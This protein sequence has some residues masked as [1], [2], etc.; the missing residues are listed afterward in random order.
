MREKQKGKLVRPGTIHIRAMQDVDGQEACV[1]YWRFESADVQGLAES[2]ARLHI[3][4]K[5]D[6]DALLPL[7]SSLS[8]GMEELA[9]D[10]AE[11]EPLPDAAAVLDL[12]AEGVEDALDEAAQE[13]ALYK[14][15]RVF[16]ISELQEE[17]GPPADAS[18][19]E[20]ES[21][22]A[23]APLPV[24]ELKPARAPKPVTDLKPT[25]APRAA[26][27]QAPTPVATQHDEEIDDRTVVDPEDMV[28]STDRERVETLQSRV[29][30]PIE[31]SVLI[32][33]LRTVTV[34]P[35]DKRHLAV[36]IIRCAGPKIIDVEY[37][38]RG[39]EYELAAASAKIAKLTL[40]GDLT[41]FIPPGTSGTLWRAGAGASHVKLNG[42]PRGC[43]QKQAP[44]EVLELRELE[45]SPGQRWLIRQ[46]P[47]EA[48][49]KPDQAPILAT[50]FE[51]S[52][53][54]E[55]DTSAS[56]ATH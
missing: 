37:L 7:V 9:G 12:D 16:D 54:W 41:T 42:G 31:G 30:I 55:E 44:C 18:A 34:A 10:M 46:I 5:A 49:L 40:D 35:G 13:A 27:P 39:A 32:D 25:P 38:L 19:L 23:P 26:R 17:V 36:E 20:P 1:G 52:T 33:N 22:V 3:L 24:A 53:H 15:H 21:N 28:E 43:A 29:S 4:L 48:C 8:L 50:V 14:V 51:E 47:P 6:G 45:G 2:L 56:D 11:N